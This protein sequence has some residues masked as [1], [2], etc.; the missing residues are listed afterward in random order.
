[1]EARQKAMFES[2]ISFLR[3]KSTKIY[4]VSLFLVSKVLATISISLFQCDSSS[5]TI[6][7]SICLFCHDPFCLPYSTVVDHLFP[8]T[9]LLWDC[10]QSHLRYMAPARDS[11]KRINNEYSIKPNWG[12][13]KF[14]TF[15]KYY[16][17]NFTWS[18]VGIWALDV[19]S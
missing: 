8:L 14:R 3:N 15:Q 1:M 2:C 9:F 5:C 7:L 6:R 18:G 4:K 19:I 13:H 16:I 17:N 11:G 12:L 10:F